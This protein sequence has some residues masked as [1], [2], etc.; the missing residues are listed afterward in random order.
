MGLWAVIAADAAAGVYLLAW[1]LRRERRDKPA[2]LAVGVLLLLCAATLG[3]LG[4]RHG[5]PPIAPQPPA[6]STPAAPDGSTGPT[7]QV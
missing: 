2:V 5:D 1:A 6:P 4:A 3:L 7:V